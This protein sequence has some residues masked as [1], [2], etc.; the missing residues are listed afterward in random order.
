MC[1]YNRKTFNGGYF[2]RQYHDSL[3]QDIQNAVIFEIVEIIPFADC[4][5]PHLISEHVKIDK[6]YNY[7]AAFAIDVSHTPEND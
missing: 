2:V 6:L 5:T 7:Y 3:A 1:F 4:E